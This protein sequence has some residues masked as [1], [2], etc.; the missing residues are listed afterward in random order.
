MKPVLLGII[1]GAHGIRG[2]VVIK[3]FTAAAEAIATY[4]PLADEAGGLHEIIACRPTAKGLV[5]T[6]KGVGDRS[7]A[8]RLKGTRLSVPRERLP[9]A[10]E[11]EYYHADL[12]GLSAHHPDGRQ[13]GTVIGVQNFGAGDL[14]EIRLDGS[15]RSELVPFTDAFVPVVDLGG[16]RIVVAVSHTTDDREG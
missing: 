3:T 4:G 12:V 14:I 6:L 15:S 11:R 2:E 5:A 10:D 1:V 8:E 9:P 13:L 16:G 7:A